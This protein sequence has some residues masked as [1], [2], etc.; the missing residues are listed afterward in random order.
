MEN[1]NHILEVSN[2]SHSF[3]DEHRREL[4][5]L[6]NVSFKVRSGKLV[7]LV[8]PSGCGKSTLL[9]IIAGL[10]KA[11]HGEIVRHYETEAMVFQH[12]AIFPWLT[13]RENVAFG[14]KMRGNLP[15]HEQERIVR[16]KI[17]EVGLTNFS[18]AYPRELS[19]GQRQRVGIARALAVHPEILLMDE[20]FSALDSFNATHLQE[21]ITRIWQ[22]YGMTILLVTHLIEE[23]VSLADEIIVFS[24]QPGRVKA[25][26]SI[27][28]PR[29][30]E[31]RSE[32]FYRLVDRITAQIEQ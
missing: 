31:K 3:H 17:E 25:T 30:R 6:L 18:H 2:V 27:D 8:G 10:I 16:N 24:P 13:V 21:D 22:K 12:F 15:S 23:A 29:P 1:K 11:E 32:S 20:P 19:G 7:A 14:L 4:R 28:L 5:G 26:F 9:R